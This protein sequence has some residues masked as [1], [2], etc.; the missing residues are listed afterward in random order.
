MGRLPSLLKKGGGERKQKKMV[1][2][3][4]QLFY[5]NHKGRKKGSVN[6]IPL[7]IV[8]W[9]SKLQKDGFWQN[10]GI[11]IV[12]ISFFRKGSQP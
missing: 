8:P 10:T 3:V 11:G 5:I 7:P 6:G 1:S 12:A 9:R 2:E 4:L